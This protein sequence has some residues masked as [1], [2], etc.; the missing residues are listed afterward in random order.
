MLQFIAA[1]NMVANVKYLF[2]TNFSFWMKNAQTLV[3]HSNYYPL[4]K[5]I[6]W[7]TIFSNLLYFEDLLCAFISEY[8]FY[9]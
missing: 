5:S 3:K 6:I 2:V 7:P 4:N 9:V 8:I 1:L